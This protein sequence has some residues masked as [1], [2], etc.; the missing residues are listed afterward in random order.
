V[1]EP[2][3]E[4]I[5]RFYDAV[6]AKVRDGV[7]NDWYLR[8]MAAAGGPVLEIGVG[9]GRL[10][11]EARRRRI[12][13]WG[14]DLSPAMI[15]CC[16]AK[17]EPED[18]QRVSVAD[19]VTMRPERRFALV[20]APF[21]VLSHVHGTDDQLRLLDAVHD[22][23]VPGGEFAFDL[24]VPD[25][26]MIL[27]GVPEHADFDGEYAPGRRLRRLVQAAPGDLSTQRSRVRMAFRWDEEDGEH[28]DE[29]AFE[30]RFFFRFEIEHL[31]A[32]TRLTIDTIHGDFG[33]GPVTADSREFVVVC[34]KPGA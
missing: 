27:E 17:L 26:R 4:L 9:T 6:Y 12:D 8:R 23:L 5:A 21:R 7:D 30:M 29:W 25:L 2:Y 15:A 20:C 1:S 19:A 24:Y 22:C 11:A 18:R 31:V 33:G 16:R 3:P 10:F 32:R 34:R 28:H 13:A 14:I